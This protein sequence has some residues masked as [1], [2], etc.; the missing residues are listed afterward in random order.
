MAGLEG[1]GLML[2]ADVGGGVGGGGGGG[3]AAAAAYIVHVP[4]HWCWCWWWCGL[5][6]DGGGFAVVA[7]PALAVVDLGEGRAELDAL[8]AICGGQLL[9]RQKKR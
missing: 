8:V 5:P 1:W 6:S 9:S 7:H 3:G 2:G 4:L